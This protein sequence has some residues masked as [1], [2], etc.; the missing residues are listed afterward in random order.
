[1][2]NP[3]ICVLNMIG[4]AILTKHGRLGTSFFHICKKLEVPIPLIL[5]AENSIRA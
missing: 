2:D 3:W 5:V 4:T 1:M